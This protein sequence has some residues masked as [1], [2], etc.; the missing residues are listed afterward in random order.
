G[1]YYGEKGTLLYPH[2]GAPRLIPEERMK[3]FKPPEPSLPRGLDHYQEW[4]HA[5]KGGSKPLS[6]F[7]YA[8][9]LSEA[10][11]LGNVAV[12]AGGKLLWDAKNLR[13]TNLER[14]NDFL[15]REYRQGWSL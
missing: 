13:C 3:G 5:C 10:V 9:P 4:I 7:D 1:L 12:R 15:Q 8:G 11:L 6:N 2:M 14:A